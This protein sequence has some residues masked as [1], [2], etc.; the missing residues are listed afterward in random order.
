MALLLALQG[1]APC[2]LLVS[3]LLCLACMLR[4]KIQNN[5][6][7]CAFLGVKT[8]Q[9]AVLFAACCCVLANTGHSIR[10]CVS[11]HE[12]RHRCFGPCGVK[13]TYFPRRH[14][15]A[16]GQWEDKSGP[17][18]EWSV[19]ETK[20][21][22]SAQCGHRSLILTLHHTASHCWRVFVGLQYDLCS[23]TAQKGKPPASE[24]VCFL[25]NP[26]GLFLPSV[27]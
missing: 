15:H 6:A 3:L 17:R 12:T 2:L 1:C 27:G 13:L 14:A 7:G 9:F 4:F 8:L 16:G 24:Y 5:D 11:Q 18:E 10:S 25:Q 26:D 23:V 21:R 20:K 19:P 22:S